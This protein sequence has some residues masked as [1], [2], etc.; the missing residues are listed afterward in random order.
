MN[1]VFMMIDSLNVR[2]AMQVYRQLGKYIEQMDA[3]ALARDE[4]PENKSIDVHFRSGVYL[5]VGM[6]HIIISLMPARLAT[7]VELFGYKGN[8]HLGLSLL[9]KAGGWTK[10][11]PEPAVSQGAPIDRT[12]TAKAVIN[13]GSVLVWFSGRGCA[14]QYLRHV[15]SDLPPL[16]FRFHARR[17]RR[18]DGP[19]NCR[20][21]SQTLSGR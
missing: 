7:L 18:N 16:S 5:G 20:L 15:A 13:R 1:F 17:R 8:R 4:G 10:E 14:A 11:S 19:E 9:E 12:I 21:E 2:S 6:S 3:E